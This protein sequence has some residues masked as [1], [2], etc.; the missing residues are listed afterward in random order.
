MCQCDGAEKYRDVWSHAVPGV[1][2]STFLD[3]VSV[4]VRGLSEDAV[5]SQVWV[6]TV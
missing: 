6:D 4:R 5:P 1:S 3:A 2:A